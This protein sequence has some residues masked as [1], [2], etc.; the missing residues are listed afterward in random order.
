MPNRAARWAR[1]QA[2]QVENHRPA[3]LRMH[4]VRRIAEKLVVASGDALAA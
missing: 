2:V 1:G 4:Q 3:E